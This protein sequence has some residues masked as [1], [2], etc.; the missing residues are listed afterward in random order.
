MYNFFQLILNRK[1]KILIPLF[2]SILEMLMKEVFIT[3]N[4]FT[5]NDFDLLRTTPKMYIYKLSEKGLSNESRRVA[6]NDF[7]QKLSQYKTFF[8][9]N[10]KKRTRSKLVYFDF[11]LNFVLNSLEFIENSKKS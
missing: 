3:A 4:V 5:L 9:S 1:D 2:E 11:L 7:I 10:D 6:M 8:K